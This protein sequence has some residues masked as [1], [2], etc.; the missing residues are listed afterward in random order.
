V[1]SYGGDCYGSPGQART[2][3]HGVSGLD[4]ERVLGSKTQRRR[5]TDLLGDQRAE[6]RAAPLL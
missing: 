2:G 4:A 1:E 5:A 6:V 3:S